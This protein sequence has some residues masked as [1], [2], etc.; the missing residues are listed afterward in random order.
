MTSKFYD[1]LYVEELPDKG[2]SV[3]AKDIIS[4]GSNITSDNLYLYAIDE[5]NTSLRCH[6][7]CR[8]LSKQGIN[9]CSICK[10]QYYCNVNCQRNAWKQKHWLECFI[11]ASIK[12]TQDNKYHSSIV[13]LLLQL[14][15][16]QVI[17]HAIEDVE[18][19]DELQN[20]AQLCNHVDAISEHFD[21]NDNES[22][23]IN[24]YTDIVNM[25]HSMITELVKCIKQSKQGDRN[26]LLSPTTREKLM[27]FDEDFIEGSLIDKSKLLYDL[28]RLQCNIW[29]LSDSNDLSIYGYTLM[30]NYA[31]INHSCI[32][33]VFIQ[34]NGLQGNLRSIQTI[35][36]N[37]ELCFTYIDLMYNTEDRQYK[38][39]SQYNFICKC[40]R[41]EYANTQD[42][43]IIEYKLSNYNCNNQVSNNNCNGYLID[44]NAEQY[45][46]TIC[47]QTRSISS[48]RKYQSESSILLDAADE[49]YQHNDIEQ[50]IKLCKQ[51]IQQLLHNVD[52]CNLMLYR[53]VSKLSIYANAAEEYKLL[54]HILIAQLYA[55]RLCLPL[56]H[57]QLG[58]HYKTIADVSFELQYGKLAIEYYTK[59][60]DIL[61][62]THGSEHELTNEVNMKLAGWK[63]NNNR[64]TKPYYIDNSNIVKLLDK[65]T[66]S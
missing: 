41:C 19:T 47:Q 28:N 37:T 52:D 42:G 46:C 8:L 39:K 59:S 51:A 49:S 65:I 12:P 58:L 48:L 14:V 53:T 5:N 13:L 10:Q 22:Y 4:S 36:P 60:Y 64:Q 63:H 30:L 29:T 31:L 11:L 66:S 57:P 15:L 23:D 26:K 17:H 32:P 21:S 33:N 62:I 45:I 44:Y 18:L 3:F 55:M 34:Y 25:V 24:D 27:Q 2:R 7:C 61:K 20:F 40:Q 16:Q 35:Q 9:C 50:S 38:L 6:Y 54:L 43:R 1:K 56:Y